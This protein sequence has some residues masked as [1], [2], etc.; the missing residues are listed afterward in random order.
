MAVLNMLLMVDNF[1][2]VYL[3]LVGQMTTTMEMQVSFPINYDNTT[4]TISYNTSSEGL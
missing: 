3:C 4:F 1:T 2:G